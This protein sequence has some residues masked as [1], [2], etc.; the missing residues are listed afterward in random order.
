MIILAAIPAFTRPGADLLPQ[1]SLIALVFAA[2]GVPSAGL[3]GLIGT[4]AR[5]VLRQGRGLR[6]FNIAMALLM[7]ASLIPALKS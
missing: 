7:L 1:V 4:G 3:W 6:A 2:V 5:R